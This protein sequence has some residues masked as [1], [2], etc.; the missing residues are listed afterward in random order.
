MKSSNIKIIIPIVY[1]IVYLVLK[2]YENP[3]FEYFTQENGKSIFNNPE[4][5]HIDARGNSIRV[6]FNKPQ[7][8]GLVKYHLILNDESNNKLDE[9]FIELTENNILEEIFYSHRIIPNNTYVLSIIALNSENEP[10]EATN[11]NIDVLDEARE[12]STNLDV[13]LLSRLA[14][15][16]ERFLKQE[17]EQVVQNRKIKKL[18]DTLDNF[19][20]DLTILR[21]NDKEELKSIYNKLGSTD[22]LSQAGKNVTSNFGSISEDS[23]D[24]FNLNFKLDNE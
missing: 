3:K 1:I 21:N 17:R 8:I 5:S 7:G 9:K 13:Q 22:T 12:A 20:K 19:R 18:K 6:R 16:K 14:K 23:Y 24:T 11:V 2:I 4:I 10:G 15:D